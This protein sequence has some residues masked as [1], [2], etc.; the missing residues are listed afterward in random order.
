MKK[1]LVFT[2]NRADYGLLKPILTYIQASNILQLFLCVSGSHLSKNHGYTISEIESDGFSISHKIDIDL[3]SDSPS[4]ICQSMANGLSQYA[5]ILD[6]EKPDI[7][8]VLGDRFE[9]FSFATAC[10]VMRVPLAHL[11]GGESTIGAIDESIRHSITKM[12]HFHF[13]STNICRNRV[14]QLGENPQHV[15]SVG[16]TGIDSLLNEPLT[17][18][19]SLESELDIV[20]SETNFLITLHP[21]TLEDNT[22]LLYTEQLLQALSHLK[23]VGLFFTSANADADGQIINSC[24]KSFVKNH[25]SSRPVYFFD[26]LGIRNYQSLMAQMTGVIGNSSSGL[27]EAPSFK[28]GTINIGDRQKGRTQAN[29]I[30]QCSPVSEHILTAIRTLKSSKFQTN[31]ITT[32]N[33]YGDGHSSERIVSIL[34][35]LS[36][37]NVLK[38]PFYGIPL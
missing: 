20:F 6:V 32:N 29:S 5:H 26:S 19:Q 24:I 7:A 22:S 10:M 9:A 1:L 35:S 33:P 12:S 34:E 18:R 3:L 17:S 27:I 14:I 30:I 11:Y 8:L 13:T 31:L 16:S 38:K 15:W 4:G 21:V 25:Q 36:L 37:E 2:G 28:I 23:D